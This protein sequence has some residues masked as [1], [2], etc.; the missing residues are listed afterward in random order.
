MVNILTFDASNAGGMEV[1]TVISK[2]LAYWKIWRSDNSA[3]ISHQV[4][5]NRC[6][7]H[8]NRR[9]HNFHPQQLVSLMF[10]PPGLL[11]AT[12]VTMPILASYP[13]S[14]TSAPF[15]RCLILFLGDVFTS[16][17]QLGAITRFEKKRQKN[18]SLAKI[19]TSPSKPLREWC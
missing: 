9:E 18:L 8:W 19:Q 17:T 16:F 12:E 10:R 13:F 1:F 4:A 11:I 6:C 7:S 14:L 2:L 5:L 3:T 15:T